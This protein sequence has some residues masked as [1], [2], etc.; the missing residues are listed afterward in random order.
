MKR[1]SNIGMTRARFP[2]RRSKTCSSLPVPGSGSP[3]KTSAKSLPLKRL[4]VVTLFPAMFEGPMSESLLG[5][6]RERRVLDVRIHNLRDWSADE[7][8]RTVD[9]RPYGGGP[10]MVIQ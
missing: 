6:A 5:R 7:R 3:P 2:A 4:D 10:G 9:D 8:H 1:G